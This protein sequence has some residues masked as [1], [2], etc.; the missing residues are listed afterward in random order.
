MCV[1]C[2][3]TIIF[4]FVFIFCVMSIRMTTLLETI[5]NVLRTQSHPSSQSHLQ[6]NQWVWSYA[7]GQSLHYFPRTVPKFEHLWRNW[8]IQ[9]Q[10]YTKH[11]WISHWSRV[12]W[13]WYN[14]RELISLLHCHPVYVFF[15]CKVCCCKAYQSWSLVFLLEN[16]LMWVIFNYFYSDWTHNSNPTWYI[17]Y[18]KFMKNMIFQNGPH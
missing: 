1:Y 15:D 6:S 17:Y 4:L 5:N 7:H 2:P 14:Y 8:W 13:S 10:R 3:V 16:I 11:S 9:A 18:R 12:R